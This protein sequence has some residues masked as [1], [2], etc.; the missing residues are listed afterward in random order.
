MSD[1][2]AA[3]LPD[4]SQADKDMRAP[5]IEVA[6]TK[7]KSPPQFGTKIDGKPNGA[8]TIRCADFDA[9]APFERSTKMRAGFEVFVSLAPWANFETRKASSI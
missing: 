2:S 4:P 1:Y 5:R 3:M 9:L 8:K 7:R 6:A